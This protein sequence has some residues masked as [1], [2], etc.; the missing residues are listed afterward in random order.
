LDAWIAKNPNFLRIAT[1]MA[2]IGFYIR[3]E[4]QCRNW[5]IIETVLAGIFALLAAI[6]S[7][8]LVRSFCLGFVQ[9]L[10]E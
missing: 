7:F 4:Y 9:V 8:V 10:D 3:W 6:Y 1:S 5:G 2:F